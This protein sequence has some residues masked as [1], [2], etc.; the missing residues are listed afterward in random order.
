MSNTFTMRCPDNWHAHFR[1][2][3][4]GMMKLM[5][6]LL[7]EGG[8]RGRVVA[9]PNTQPPILTW[10]QA[11]EYG[12]ELTIL[13]R[14]VPGGE[15][16]TPIVAIQITE[17]TTPGMI[18]EAADHGIMVAKV[19]PKN[20][21]T[22]SECGVLEYRNIIPA[23]KQCAKRRIRVQ[24]H[25]ESPDPKVRGVDKEWVFIEIIKMILGECPDLLLSVEHVSDARMIDFIKSCPSNVVGGLAIQHT[26]LTQDDILGYTAASF[27]LMQPHWHNKPTPKYEWD[28]EAI[29]QAATSGNPKFFAANDDAFHP[30]SSKHSSSVCAGCANTFASLSLWVELFKF[31]DELSRLEAFLSEYGS[32][33]YGFPLNT[34]RIELQRTKDLFVP[35]FH[36]LPGCSEATATDSQKVIPFLA[37]RKLNW[38]LIS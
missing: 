23:L 31:Y 8:W 22:H 20:M 9:E 18:E 4:S 37:G 12:R 24:F 33:H 29:I 34:H 2:K 7:I 16:F 14:E 35:N 6:K 19:Y 10:E 28:R 15:T 21:T 1:Q 5:V 3:G 13:A 26:I 17:N 11:I 38:Q 30:V 25:A 36:F 32:R 27:Y